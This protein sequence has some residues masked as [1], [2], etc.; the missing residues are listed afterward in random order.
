MMKT[1]TIHFSN[2]VP[3]DLEGLILPE[4]I[5]AQLCTYLEKEHAVSLRMTAVPIRPLSMFTMYEENLKG[6]PTMQ[7][8]SRSLSE[9]LA[10]FAR[11]A[12]ALADAG[13][14]SYSDEV[15]SHLRAIINFWHD[16]REAYADSTPYLATSLAEGAQTLVNDIP[17][18]L[19][20]Y[21]ALVVPER[22]WGADEAEPI[23]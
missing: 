7:D 23:T 9:V 13:T 16:A 21:P 19:E 20:T 22:I 1:L 4:N 17:W 14:D 12:A 8:A 10:S 18:M 3:N 15:A 6:L 11:A 2:N 5:V